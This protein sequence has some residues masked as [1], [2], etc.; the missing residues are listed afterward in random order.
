MRSHF[1]LF[2]YGTLRAGG[3]ADELLAG[4][5]RVAQATVAGTLYDIDGQ[6]PALVL[7]G[8]GRVEGEVWRCPV[9]RLPALDAY[10][11]VD[12][13]LFRRVGVQVGEY[14]CWTYVAGPKLASR[15]TADRRLARER[16]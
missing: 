5:D 2:V 13:G 4:C 1:H 10:E 11:G 7:A 8:Q 14:A 15:L 6:Y 16:W 12:D 9:D 3:S